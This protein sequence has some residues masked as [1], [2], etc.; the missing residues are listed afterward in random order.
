MLNTALF[1]K[2]RNNSSRLSGNSEA[3]ASE[4]KCFHVTTAVMSSAA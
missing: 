3:K 4:L 1:I 2:Y